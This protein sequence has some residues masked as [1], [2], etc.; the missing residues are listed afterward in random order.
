MEMTHAH[1]MVFVVEETQ[2]SAAR[3]MA[4]EIADSVGFDEADSYR[5][6]LVATELATNLTKHARGGEILARVLNSGAESAVELI[7]VDRGPGIRDMA[8]A[9]ADGHSTAGSPGNGLGAIRRLSDLFDIHTTEGRGTVILARLGRKRSLQAAE[10]ILE[11]AGVS[12]PKSGETACGDAWGVRFGPEGAYA[13]V[14]DGLGHGQYAAEAAAAALGA[15]ERHHA[16]GG[17]HT[18]QEMHLAARHTRGAA[19]AIAEVR[20][21][22]RQLKYSGVGNIAAGIVTPQGL[23]H[24]VSHAGTLGHEARVFREYSYPWEPGA[25][26]V[27]HSDGLS[28]HWS[29]DGFAGLARRH[30]AVVAA[31]LYREFSR[32][33]DDVTV[34]VGR[35]RQ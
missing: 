16:R 17:G 15:F 5:A 25:M 33:R 24:A 22:A 12:L 4:R 31:V 32:N 9:I 18:L 19:G 13:A 2:P 29:F 35:E 34:V 23:R 6:G 7:A 1:Q 30:P 27:M 21:R 20:P 26:L 8:A 28:S 10:G 11:F 14:V 3:F